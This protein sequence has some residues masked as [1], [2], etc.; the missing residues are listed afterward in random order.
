MEELIRLLAKH[1][2]ENPDAVFEKVKKYIIEDRFSNQINSQ[3]CQSVV[4]RLKYR[5]RSIIPREG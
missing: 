1:L 5:K 3:I 2:E 4:S